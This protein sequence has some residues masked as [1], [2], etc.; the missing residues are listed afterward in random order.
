MTTRTLT[1]PGPHRNHPPQ[2]VPEHH[3]SVLLARP[4]PAVPA[5]F[6]PLLEQVK[7]H[8]IAALFGNRRES[9]TE[10]LLQDIN[11]ALAQPAQHRPRLSLGDV[12]HPQ[13]RR[14]A[15]RRTQTLFPSK[16]AG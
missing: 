9:D 6:R 16:Q 10:R 12:L 13:R 5:G 15:L 11:W 8:L 7:K 3:L 4:A 1:E 14:V 2:P